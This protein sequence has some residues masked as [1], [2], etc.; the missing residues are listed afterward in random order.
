MIFSRSLKPRTVGW[1]ILFAGF[2][3]KVPAFFH[4]LLGYFS[5]YQ[6]LNAMFAEMML[7]GHWLDVR[8]FILY[9]G[10]PALH[11]IYYPFGS[12]FAA[13]LK[14]LLGGNLDFW[15]RFQAGLCSLIT[16]LIFLKIYNAQRGSRDQ[17][18]QAEG[19]IALLFLTFSP[20]I[21]VMG[22]GLQNESP[23]LLFLMGSIYCLSQPSN[24][25]RII[26]GGILFSLSVTA[27]LHFI[28]VVPAILFLIVQKENKWRTM[29]LFA[30]AAAIPV[31]LWFFYAYGLEKKFPSQ[32][33]TSLFMQAG[34]GRLF[35]NSLFLEL[36]FYQRLA[37]GFLGFG[38]TPV[39]FFLSMFGF[40]AA[41]KPYRFFKLWA[42]SALMVIFLLPQKVLDHPFYLI[43]AVPP[44]CVL[45]AHSLIRFGLTKRPRLFAGLLGLFFLFSLRY[46]IPPA[47]SNDGWGKIPQI[48]W[49]VQNIIPSDAR[50]I[51]ERGST[52]DLLYYAKRFGWG[53]DLQMSPEGLGNQPR[54]VLL[55]QQGY[56]DPAVWLEKL[57]KDG[58]R[59]L[60]ISDKVKFQRNEMFFNYINSKFARVTDPESE[61]L[62]FDLGVSGS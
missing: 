48:G 40:A 1:I 3:L 9:D 55:K 7:R 56:G 15:G 6:T 61:F 39:V 29:V 32:T 58:A 14:G 43:A 62:I 38:L 28:T 42:L 21:L 35:K 11:L 41:P 44:L 47:F 54:H 57:R 8:S 30:F 46:Y 45:A 50:I 16:G 36:G 53:F 20:L 27:R 34:E 12:L 52:P 10:E 4:P 24:L 51:A 5:S 31:F 59:F 22:I 19:N 25:C 17:E 18:S 13:L 23:A 49:E 37:S 33:M 60:I 26:I 2:L